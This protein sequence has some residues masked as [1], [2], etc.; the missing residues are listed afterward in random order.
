MTQ[1][2]IA[3]FVEALGSKA[4][5]PGGG[6]AAAVVAAL[7]AALGKMVVEYSAGK[8]SLA[9]N[10]ALHERA[11]LTLGALAKRAIELGEADAKAYERL[12]ALWKLDANDARKKREMPDAVREAIAAPNAVMDVCEETLG[13]AEELV[14]KSNTMLRSDLAIA[15]ILAEAGMRSAA[16]NVRINLTLLED[17]NEAEGARR[18]IDE[19]LMRAKAACERIDAACR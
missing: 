10:E 17:P 3:E 12:N 19:R 13:L 18:E 1:M 16:W 9:G 6:A 14:G 8:K 7:G 2:K 4:P 5:V 11:M 15:A